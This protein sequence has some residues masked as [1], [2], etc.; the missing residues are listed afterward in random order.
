MF[1]LH[2]ITWLLNRRTSKILRENE[3]SEEFKRLEQHGLVQRLVTES[4]DKESC[5]IIHREV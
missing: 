5:D 1:L 3:E 2:F 4:N